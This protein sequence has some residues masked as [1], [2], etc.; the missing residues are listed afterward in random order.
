MSYAVLKLIHVSCVVLSIA[1]FLVRGV[2]ML[3]DSPRLGQRWVRTLPH[4]VDTVLL[5]SA[6]LLA[7]SLRQY[8][9]VNG[10]LTAKLLALLSYIG[11]G[12]I[13][14]RRGPTKGIRTAAWVAAIG[15]YAYIVSVALTRQAA[16]WLAL[17]VP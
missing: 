2:W 4:V 16:P 7:L 1:F 15:V 9:F 17:S 12:T 8:P 5:G 13:A 3:G 6:I 14:I 10:W 11:L